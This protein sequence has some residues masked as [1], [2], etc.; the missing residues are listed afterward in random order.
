M[1]VSPSG[2]GNGAGVARS[3]AALT[4]PPRRCAGQGQRTSRDHRHQLTPLAA[5]RVA[6]GSPPPCD[7][8]RAIPGYLEKKERG[9]HVV[10]RVGLSGEDVG[11]S[12]EDVGQSPIYI[13][14]VL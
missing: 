12:G 5:L 13:R 1:G 3:L 8:L 9:G 2:C 14:A 6:R 4:S 7:N 11:L 10:D